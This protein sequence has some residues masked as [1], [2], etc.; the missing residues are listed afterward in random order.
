MQWSHNIQTTPDLAYGPYPAQ[1][2]DLTRQVRRVGEPGFIE[3]L[4]GPAPLLVWIHGGGWIQGDKATQWNSTIP[5]LERR[6]HVANV[7]YRQGPG[8]SPLAIHDCMAA[9]QWLVDNRGE[10]QLDF[11]RVVVSGASA[12]GHLALTTGLAATNS[13]LGHDVTVSVDAIVNWYGITDIAAVATFLD[14]TR[15][16][17]NYAR[18]WVGGGDLDSVS[19]D[20]SPVRMLHDA[21]PPILTIHG[22]ADTVVPHSQARLLHDEL[23][24]R[25]RPGMLLTLDGGNHSGFSHEQ[26]VEAWDTVFDFLG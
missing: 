20:W 2:L 1:R 12:G 23:A 9:L 15:P 26:Y 7:N 11:D 14:S 13:N 18:T 5:F 21:S 17:G 10:L 24:S 8:T 6:W 22:D 4:H 3:P 19:A 16:G 25:G